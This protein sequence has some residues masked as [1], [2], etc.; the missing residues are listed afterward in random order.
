M[1]TKIRSEIPRNSDK[2]YQIFIK[3]GATNLMKFIE[4]VAP[5]LM[6]ICRNLASNFRTDYQTLLQFTKLLPGNFLAV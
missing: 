1:C 6:K 4:S 5:I 2:I 3:I